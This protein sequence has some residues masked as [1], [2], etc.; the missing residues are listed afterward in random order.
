MSNISFPFS[1]SINFPIAANTGSS[2]YADIKMFH[3]IKNIKKGEEITTSYSKPFRPF[4]SRDRSFRLN[5]GFTCE[6]RLCQLD[7]NDAE[8]EERERLVEKCEEIDVF[9]LDED[10]KVYE[11]IVKLT[12]L[13]N[14]AINLV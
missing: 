3:A 14:Q 10:A 5:Y 8:C 7:R 2:T 11:V 12:S 1:K 4:P 13:L 9:A 6:C